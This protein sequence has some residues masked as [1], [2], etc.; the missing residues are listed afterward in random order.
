MLPWYIEGYIEDLKLWRQIGQ[1]SFIYEPEKLARIDHAIGQ[2]KRGN[3]SPA[4]E[5][6]R[7][8]IEWGL[9]QHGRKNY[10]IRRT[11]MH[12]ERGLRT[13]LQYVPNQAVH[14]E[15]PFPFFANFCFS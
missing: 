6:F 4:Q 12:L 5:F 10:S 15:P 8:E 9:G 7:A 3:V 2:F 14:H 13:L 11:T 1:E